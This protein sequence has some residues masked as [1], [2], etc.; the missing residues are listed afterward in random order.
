[1]KQCCYARFDGDITKKKFQ[2]VIQIDIQPTAFPLL[3]E[4]ES[5]DGKTFSEL[6]RFL[7]LTV[8]GFS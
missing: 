2:I 1:M 6:T 8:S 4:I 3:D 7:W 5:C